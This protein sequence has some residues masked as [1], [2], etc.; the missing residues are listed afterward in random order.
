MFATFVAAYAS[1]KTVSVF[2]S[3]GPCIHSNSEPIA[4]IYVMD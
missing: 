1:G 3:G 2:G 4:T